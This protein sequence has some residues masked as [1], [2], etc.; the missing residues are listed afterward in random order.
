MGNERSLAP[1]HVGGACLLTPGRGHRRRPAPRGRRRRLVDALS[2]ASALQLDRGER[3][4]SYAS[5]VPSVRPFGSGPTWRGLSV[6]VE[7]LLFV[8]RSGGRRRPHLRL[9]PDGLAV[10]SKDTV[11]QL[12]DWDAGQRSEWRLMGWH[13]TKANR[14]GIRIS[15]KPHTSASS[16]TPTF[17]F[18]DVWLPTNWRPLPI[19]ELPALT[20]YLM[21]TPPARAN[22]ADQVRQAHLITALSTLPKKPRAPLAPSFGDPLDIF[23]AVSAALGARGWRTFKGRPVR[24]EPLPDADAVVTHARRLLSIPVARRITDEQLHST[25]AS[26]LRVAS[27]PFDMLVDQ[28]PDP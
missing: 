15:A 10:V 11:Q 4:R 26:F 27:W 3:A 2:F 19:L 22:L 7:G 16:W 12:L 18:P 28:P 13:G 14:E 6:G 5:F 23:V 1:V 9:Q 20:D 24:G 17:A 21:A 25:V 8:P